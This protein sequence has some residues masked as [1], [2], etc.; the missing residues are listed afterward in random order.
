MTIAR[1]EPAIPRGP[2]VDYSP[3]EDL[4]GWIESNFK[5]YGDI[6]SARA[7]GTNIYVVSSPEYADHVLRKNWRNYKKG[8]AIKR[9]AMLLGNGLMVSEGETWK[10]Q[11]QMI[12]PA[13]HHHAI[14][15]I[16]KAITTANVA[17]LE[18]WQDAARRNTSVNLTRDLSLT[19]LDVLL[20]T[21]FGDD[22]AQV[23]PRFAILS[24]EPVRDLAFAQAFTSLRGIVAEIVA[25]RRKEQRVGA[26]SLGMLM[27]AR[28][29]NGEEMR[30][31]QL[32][33]EIMTILVAGHETTASTLNFVW[34]LLSQHPEAEA[35]LSSELDASFTTEIPRLDELPKFNYTRKVI[36]E[37]LRLYPAGWLLTRKALGDDQLGAYFVPAGTEIYI[38]PYII[39]RRPD[40]WEDPDRF[41]PGRFELEHREDPRRLAFLPFSAGP[42]NCIGELFA[43]IEMQIHLMIIARRLRLRSDGKAQVELEAGVNLRN[44]HDFI[45]FPELKP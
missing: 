11:R 17:L 7:Y 41:N 40:L 25:R 6:Y 1:Q 18:K 23:A 38:S 19:I 5:R 35:R 22:C 37:T 30:L 3:T 10:S 32:V 28:D 39:Q 8:Q 14:G 16:A 24:N 42:R 2:S 33:N 13:F 44:K 15:M 4:F 26:D 29:Q 27:A 36:D 12:H 34:Y 9:I 43:R 21:T 31:P 20:I 45:M